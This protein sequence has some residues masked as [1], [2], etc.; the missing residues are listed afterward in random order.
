M[1]ALRD[2][3]LGTLSK[4][5]PEANKL[6]VAVSGGPDSVA[7]VHLLEGADYSL[8]LAHFDH[9]LR[10]SSA[11][12]AEFVGSLAATLTL[13]FHTERTEVAAVAK[14]KGWNVEDGARRLRYGFLTRTAKRVGAQA[15]VTGH[16]QDDQAETVLMQLLRG[17]AY[18]S[19]MKRVQG[20]VVRPLLN[21]S[22]GALLAYLRDLEQPYRE[23]ASNR[24][25]S[26][27]RAWL[28]HEV[29]PL[30]AARY[31]QV[32]S[33]L[34]R[35]AEL[36]QDQREALQLQGRAL[37]QG[38][39]LS[40]AQL[41]RAPKAVQRQALADL[42]RAAGAPFDLAGLERILA[43]LDSPHPRRHTLSEE[44]TARTA[45]GKLSVVKRGAPLPETPVSTARDLPPDL[46]ERVL[47]H[48]HLVYRSRRPGDVIRLAGG[49]KKIS[50]LLIDRKV[51]REARGELRVLASGSRVFWVEG[52][53]ADPALAKPDPD[54]LPMRRALE[55]ARRGGALGEVPVGAVVVRAGALIAEAHNETETSGDPTAHAEVLALRRAAARL[56][57][58]RL[59]DCTLVV[60]LEPCPMC[61]GA[62]LQAHLP[63]LVYGASNPREGA[64]ESVTEL[65]SA[66]WK[67]RPELRGGVLAA[68]CAAPLKAFFRRKLR[69]GE[70]R[71]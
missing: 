53:A 6:L 36:Q 63:R 19:G 35:V 56:G 30:L 60:T 62:A 13:P 41:K 12:D 18:A 39:E 16:T 55:L 57:T 5:A 46:S 59:E 15:V 66:P 71:K 22:R 14:A 70:E 17:A 21:V 2:N 43:T 49:H 68:A 47:E 27:T 67:R 26:R 54:V 11:E 42:L 1:N 51:P 31:P 4:L 65:A 44:L 37:L 7:L 32:K 61:F 29:L 45:Y 24:D 25:T 48:P 58:W 23:D 50:D 8:E 34:G 38:G 64:L 33:K 69:T 3:V 28:R 20:K 52:I 40:T 10:E 9:A